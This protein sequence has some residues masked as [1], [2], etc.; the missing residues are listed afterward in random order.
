M[1]PDPP[2]PIIFSTTLVLS[3]CRNSI[4]AGYGSMSD[5][6]QM[7]YIARIGR[8]PEKVTFVACGPLKIL[9][10]RQHLTTSAFHSVRI[11]VLKLFVCARSEGLNDTSELDCFDN[12]VLVSLFSRLTSW[13]YSS[14]I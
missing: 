8:N 12:V 11:D 5:E 9:R 6:L 14:I 13:R 10:V 4:L 2:I 1:M 7:K 3:R